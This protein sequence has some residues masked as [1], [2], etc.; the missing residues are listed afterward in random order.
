MECFTD[1]RGDNHDASQ[2]SLEDRSKRPRHSSPPS[3][4]GGMDASAVDLMRTVLAEVKCKNDKVADL[5]Q[6]VNRKND[7]VVDLLQEKVAVLQAE[8]ERLG[9]QL[10]ARDAEVDRLRAELAA[11][12]V[13]RHDGG[14]CVGI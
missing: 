3:S 11:A 9:A 7:T 8:K 13:G 10:A 5:L 1:A 4:F 6:E 14:V 12:K 2:P